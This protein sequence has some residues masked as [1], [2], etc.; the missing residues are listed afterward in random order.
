MSSIEKRKIQESAQ[1]HKG[2]RPLT[3]A[4]SITATAARIISEDTD[5]QEKA[6]AAIAKYLKTEVEDLKVTDIDSDSFKVESGN[7]EYLVFRDSDASEK[8]ALSQV[9]R[10]LE[11]EPDL[12]NQDWLQSFVKVS[13][14]DIRILAGEQADSYVDDIDD[15]R[16][17]EEAKMKSDYQELSDEVDELESEDSDLDNEDSALRKQ[18]SGNADASEKDDI[19]T[20]LDEIKTER[21]TLADKVKELK[22]KMEL[23]IDD[24]REKLRADIIKTWEDGLE[25]DPVGFLVDDQGLY[26]REDALKQSFISIDVDAAAE[27]AVSTDGVAHFLA[28]YSGDEIELDD[29]VVAYRTN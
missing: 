15:D 5:W 16:A 1:I 24:A 28:T 21:K 4:E 11:D 25:N 26:S 6:V 2:V 19:K 14:T 23:M 27:S 18:L 22:K 17:L 10:M 20:R 29:D 8:E 13:D 9:T 7:E 12:F 3:E